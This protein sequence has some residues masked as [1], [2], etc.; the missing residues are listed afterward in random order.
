[1][2]SWRTR[3]VIRRRVW[4]ELMYNSAQWC[5]ESSKGLLSSLHPWHLLLGKLG[6]IFIAVVETSDVTALNCHWCLHWALHH[7]RAEIIFIIDWGIYWWPSQLITK[8]MSGRTFQNLEQGDKIWL[9]V[10]G[11]NDMNSQGEGWTWISE[12]YKFRMSRAWF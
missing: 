7:L 9:R 4:R 3:W 5:I 2:E 1:M 12:D 8:S 11:G 6:P 10:M